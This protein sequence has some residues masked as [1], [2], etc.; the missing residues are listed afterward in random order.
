V[1]H[2]FVCSICGET[3]A[4]L[5]TDQSYQLPDV[6]WKIPEQERSKKAKFDADLCQ[7]G[8][9]Y[10]IRCILYVPFTETDGEFGWGIWVEVERSVF[11]RYLFL[12][13]VDGSGEPRHPGK[14]ANALPSYD[15]TLG[16]DVFIQFGEPE[17]RPSVH[18]PS[19]DESQLAREQRHGIDGSRYHEILS[20]L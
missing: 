8:E 6:V 9:R 14:L 12:Y 1:S 3:H 10:F 2:S 13:E 15:N 5:Q 20:V 4:G 7:Y 16:L 17:L 11:D 19:D 18:L